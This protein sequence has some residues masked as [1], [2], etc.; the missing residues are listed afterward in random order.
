MKRKIFIFAPL[1]V[2]LALAVIAAKPAGITQLTSLWIGDATQTA[3]VTPGDN[4]VYIYGTLEVDGMAYF[5]A[6]LTL[7]DTNGLVAPRTAGFTLPL[8]G[9]YVN[10]AGII[11]TTTTPDMPATAVD[12]LPVIV[13]ANSTE[14]TSI[15]WTFMLPYDYS[16]GLSFRMMISSSTNSSYAS[17]GVDWNIFVND[18]AAGFSAG[19]PE[20]VVWNTCPTPSVSNSFLTLT[21][22]DAGTVADLQAGDSVTVYFW[23]GG[24]A[25]GGDAITLEIKNVEVRYTA[26]R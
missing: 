2:M 16:S 8:A 26:A 19:S 25:V 17:L 24:G 21:V 14:T 18:T 10:G 6:G 5:D 22:A 4:D 15:G 3:T 23:N 20:T 13:Y 12:A 1:L 9:A 11:L 7:T